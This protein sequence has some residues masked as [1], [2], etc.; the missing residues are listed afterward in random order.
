M[1]TAEARLKQLEGG[2][3]A[4]KEEQRRK[5]ALSADK[6]YKQESARLKKGVRGGQA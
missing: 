4:W 3:G 6:L 5:Y 2:I 1:K